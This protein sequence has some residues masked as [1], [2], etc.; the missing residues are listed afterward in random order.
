MS[1]IFHDGRVTYIRAAT[2]EL[3]SLYEIRDGTPN[4]V[5]VQVENPP[6]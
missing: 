5:N 1:A 3:P 6:C 4:L 2:A